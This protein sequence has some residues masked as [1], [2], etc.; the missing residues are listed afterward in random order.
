MR[1]LIPSAAARRR[2]RTSSHTSSGQD[3]AQ[4][5]GLMHRAVLT[6]GA[7]AVLLGPALWAASPAG[8]DTNPACP[9]AFSSTATSCIYHYTGAEQDFTV[10]DRVTA[11]TITTVGAPGGKVYGN[12]A[13][14]GAVV[15]AT[16]PLPAGTTTLYAEVGGPG[17]NGGGGG[18]GQGG[19][20]GGASD[21]RTTSITQISDS[22]LTTATDTRLVVAGGGG[23]A[24]ESVGDS[25]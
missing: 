7:A 18:G 20:G 13:G 10:P 25:A 23:G 14:V 3:R 4:A 1:T 11:V 15:T 21:V 9:D 16:V 17:F 24:G 22:Q 12:D 5:R 8:A 19:A 6:A 2:H